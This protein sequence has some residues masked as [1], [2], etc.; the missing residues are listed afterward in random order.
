MKENPIKVFNRIYARARARVP[1]YEAGALATADA[2]G[3]PSVR[4]V[5]LKGA[6]EAGFVFYTNTKSRKGRDLARNPR[7]SLAFYWDQTGKQVR[8]EGPVKP[9][10]AAEAD[11]YWAT[12]PWQSRLGGIASQQSQPMSSRAVLLWRVMLLKL[13]HPG[14]NIPRPKHWTGYRIIP[15]RIEFWHRGIYRLHK[16]VLFVRSRR[17]WRRSILQP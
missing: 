4:F 5:L 12:R 16:R 3:R 13:K 10:P 6:D 2:R 9:V 15:N 11:A 17:G 8:V 14:R 1:L 7:A